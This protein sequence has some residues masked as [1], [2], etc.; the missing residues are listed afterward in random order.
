MI[1]FST[2]DYDLNPGFVERVNQIVFPDLQPENL[3]LPHRNYII[4]GLILAQTH[5][6]CLRE[7]NVSF[8]QKS[9]SQ[10][11]C[12]VSIIHDAPR[13]RIHGVFAF[14][15]CQGC[16]RQ[17]YEQRPTAFIMRYVD[18]WA[19]CNCA[20]ENDICNA[21]RDGDEVCAA[22][23]AEEDDTTFLCADKNFAYGIKNKLYLAP[24]FP[25][26]YIVGVHWE[27]I[28]R[29][30]NDVDLITD[31]NDVIDLIAHYLE[32]EKH[33]R[34][35]RDMDRWAAIMRKP[36]LDRRDPGGTFWQK[37]A[38][39]AHRC[40]E[41]R[42]IRKTVWNED[43]FD[44]SALSHFNVSALDPL[45]A[46]PDADCTFSGYDDAYAYGYT[47]QGYECDLPIV[48]LVANDEFITAGES[49]ALSWSSIVQDF[50]TSV[51]TIHYGGTTITVPRNEDGSII[52]NPTVNT[53]YTIRAVTACGTVEQSITVQ[54][55][56]AP[57]CVCPEGLPDCLILAKDSPWD[58]SAA[59]NPI[60]DGIGDANRWDGRMPLLSPCRWGVEFS[61][62]ETGIGGVY[63]ETSGDGA[64]FKA[65]VELVSCDPLIFEMSFWTRA[66]DINNVLVEYPFWKGLATNYPI[67]TYI[68]QHYGVG[69]VDG[70]CYQDTD[71][72]TGPCVPC[73]KPTVRFDPPSGSVV[74]FPTLVFLH[75]SIAGSLI[76]Y[77][78][79]EGPI[80]LYSGPISLNVGQV[81][82]ARAIGPAPAHCG[83]DEFIA[84]Y[85]A[86]SGL[87]FDFICD[88]PNDK[89]GVFGVFAPNGVQNDYHWR[90]KLTRGLVWTFRNAKIYETDASGVWVS[91]QA[92]A[93]INP[94]YP[95]ELA[96]NPFSVYPMVV[97][98]NTTQ[99]NFSYADPVSSFP[100]GATELIAYGQPFVPLTGYFRLEFT[101]DEGGAPFTIYKLI[102]HTCEPCPQGQNVIYHADCTGSITLTSTLQIGYT[103]RLYRADL[104]PCGSGVHSIVTEFI[105][106]AVPW[107]RLESGVN[108][109]TYS[110][111]LSVYCPASAVWIDGP[112]S[113][114]LVPPPCEVPDQF[115]NKRPTDCSARPPTDCTNTWI[116]IPTFGP[117]SQYPSVITVAGRSGNVIKAWVEILGLWHQY[118]D[119]VEIL[120]VGPDG[121]KVLLMNDAGGF[122]PNGVAR[123]GINLT[124]I[125]GGAAM[126]DVAKLTAGTY[127]PTN[128]NNDGTFF[129]GSAPAPPYATTLGAFIGKPCNGAW[130]LFVNDDQGQDAGGIE[131][132]WCLH[133]D[134]S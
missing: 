56:E 85:T 97:F 133:L 110:F 124:I 29:A 75:P 108:N 128:W 11:N 95:V 6:V 24:R 129:A 134:L 63:I 122:G 76:Y 117:A 52:F 111:F 65:I 55:T 90:I 106:T 1:P 112:V 14:K 27:G 109:C 107:E 89:A 38:D 100:V 78:V 77:G 121:T 82:K 74:N 68:T 17:R 28:K 26:G 45:P 58:F 71:F 132:G 3:I 7:S 46:L 39:V 53:T 91:G 64:Q 103:Y 60:T 72:D 25:C 8:F 118:M 15:P 88:G 83:G 31:D 131:I 92:W 32:G 19:V 54:V 5:I 98:K 94:I 35:D 79:D 20:T 49:V 69:V 66:R 41:E 123:P 51:V 120:L 33:L 81:L 116:S 99:L 80:H 67:A 96:P 61:E 126:P 86:D 113:E 21:R 44:D 16:T 119:D 70:Y 59:C 47:Y 114:V 57:P 36:N 23:T 93:T 10:D 87:E 30:Y 40:R 18:K 43:L 42:R 9:E 115:C 34:L 62:D 127:R 104:A 73:T 22:Q 37:L 101:M 105:A 84:I 125:D 12:N 102:P 50:D 130:K 48:S 2:D 4:N 13:G